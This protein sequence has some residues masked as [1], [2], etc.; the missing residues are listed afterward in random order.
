VDRYAFIFPKGRRVEIRRARLEEHAGVLGAA[1]MV[2]SSLDEE[3]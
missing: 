2:L 3:R 1:A